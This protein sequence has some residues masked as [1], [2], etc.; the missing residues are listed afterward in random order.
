IRHNLNQGTRDICLFEAGR[1]FAGSGG[2]DLPREREAL[3]L[4]ITGGQLEANRAQPARELDFFDLKG[5]LEGAVGAMN[6]P[7]LD[8]AA[9]SIK[10][11]RP[12]QSAAIHID[13][14]QIGSIGRL[15][16]SVAGDYKFRQPVFVA[17]LDLTSL[18][19]HPE[20]PVLYSRLPRFPS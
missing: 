3:A 15:A 18:L 12:G 2:G 8:F 19:E 13:G 5:A 11:L 9:A 20:Q 7:A 10:H 17:E 4:A 6:L 1:V 14:N 16:E